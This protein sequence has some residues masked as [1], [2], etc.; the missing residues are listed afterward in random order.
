MLDAFVAEH[1]R[2]HFID[3]IL[4]S[5]EHN[6]QTLLLGLAALDLLSAEHRRHE[7][8]QRL[9]SEVAI[10]A[11]VTDAFFQSIDDLP[12]EHRREELLRLLLR[13]SDDWLLAIPMPTSKP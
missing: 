12:A 1:R 3:L 9:A 2:A 10:D 6:A 8:L 11:A 4:K 5:S 7:V 13:H